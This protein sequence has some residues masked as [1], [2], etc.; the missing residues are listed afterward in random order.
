MFAAALVMT[1]ER[2]RHPAGAWFVVGHPQEANRGLWMGMHMCEGGG[3]TPTGLF[4]ETDFLCVVRYSGF[5]SLH[6]PN[7]L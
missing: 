7:A 2:P 5:Y 6:F 1:V 3:G 4:W